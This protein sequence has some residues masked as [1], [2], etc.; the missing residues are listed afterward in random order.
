MSDSVSQEI[1]E[2]IILHKRVVPSY[3]N[4]EILD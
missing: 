3:T 4:F 2:G 1:G